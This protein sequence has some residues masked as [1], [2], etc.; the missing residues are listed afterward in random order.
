M[1][2]KNTKDIIYMYVVREIIIIIFISSIAIKF[3]IYKPHQH[4]FSSQD[5]NT[6]FS[7][8]VFVQYSIVYTRVVSMI[9]VFLIV[10]GLLGYSYEKRIEYSKA[11]ISLKLGA[12]RKDLSD[13][14]RWQC[15]KQFC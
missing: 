3:L 13:F 10:F 1:A 12:Y 2:T 4:S 14:D 11:I 9:D 15:C 8:M 5:I 6:Y 7:T